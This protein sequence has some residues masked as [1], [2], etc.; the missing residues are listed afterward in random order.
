M[1]LPMQTRRAF[2]RS[3]TGLIAIPALESLGFGRV[4]S[5]RPKRML[6]FGLGYGVTKETWYPKP[7]DIGP[8]F[9]LPPG[10]KPR[11]LKFQ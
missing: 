2:L 5:A 9:T 6:F 11:V 8:D 4:A 7:D 1:R 10:L 3:G